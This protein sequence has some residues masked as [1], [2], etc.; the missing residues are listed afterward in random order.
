MFLRR[1]FSQMRQGDGLLTA[2][3]FV[4]ILFGLAAIYS[5]ALSQPS[6]DFLNV[7]KQL[8]ALGIGALL[9]V[10]ASMFNYRLFRNY[11]AVLYALGNFLLF[12]VLFFGET[13]RGTTGWFSVWEIHF[14]PVEPMKFVLVVVLASYF[15]QRARRVFARRELVESMAI[16]AVPVLL[17][18]FQPDLGSA[19]VFCGIWG[20]MV[21]F[22]GIPKRFLAIIFSA[23][24]A[25]GWIAWTFLFADYQRDRILTFLHPSL[26]P[27]G[28]GYNVTQAIIAIGSGGLGGRGLGF[29]SQSQLKFLPESQTDFIFAVIAEELGLVGV[30]CVLGTFFFLLFR[31]LRLAR[32]TKD[33]LAAFL[34]I[35]CGA[36][37]FL[38]A[39][40]NIGMNMGL[41]PVT[42]IGL[43]LVSYGGS[44]LMLF[45]GM[46]GVANSIAR[47]TPSSS[48]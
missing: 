48:T 14:Q 21:L 29:G 7:K 15:S 47:Q 2:T 17:T 12:F 19:L 9:Y 8:V 4:L 3:A 38:Q 31:F 26:D 43:P 25:F 23:V 32:R 27:L 45:L 35:G 39:F 20:V 33:E 16:V 11:G 30:L 5:V 34:V 10:G 44:S 40:V 36:A 41:L 42:G 22:A 1:V 6:S 24:G 46:L 28:R 13:I 18:L 37:F